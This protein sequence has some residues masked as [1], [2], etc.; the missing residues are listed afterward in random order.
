[1]KDHTKVLGFGT[2]RVVSKQLDKGGLSNGQMKS[3]SALQ[4]LCGIKK[5]ETDKSAI[6]KIASKKIES[7]SKLLSGLDEEGKNISPDRKKDEPV[8]VNSEQQNPSSTQKKK[9]S[10]RNLL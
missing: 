7:K 1:M 4:S 2:N 9:I 3:M 6:E 8:V 5:T 10:L